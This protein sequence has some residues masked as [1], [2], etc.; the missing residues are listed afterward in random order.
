M[1]HP[2]IW[3][4][5]I[6][7][8]IQISTAVLL[9]TSRALHLNVTELVNRRTMR[10]AG[11]VACTIQMGHACYILIVWMSG[12]LRQ[13]SIWGEG[14]CWRLVQHT[15]FCDETQL[16]WDWHTNCHKAQLRPTNSPLPPITRNF[17]HHLSDNS[18]AV[19][20]TTTQKGHVYRQT[21]DCSTPCE[22][23]RLWQTSL[24]GWP[25]DE[26]NDDNLNWRE[27]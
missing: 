16:P 15:L 11:N 10:R 20:A 7:A 26:A 25:Q 3:T 19:L 1:G 6:I 9:V 12:I 21:S 17:R 14:G 13:G 8:G 24:S 27:T 4:P 5:C 2:G 18:R 22:P 23:Y